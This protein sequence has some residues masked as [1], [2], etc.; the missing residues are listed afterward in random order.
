MLPNNELAK[1]AAAA[2]EWLAVCQA[3]IVMA[4]VPAMVAGS[5]AEERSR[6]ILPGLLATR[7]SGAAIIFDKLLAKM[8]QIGVFLA[9]GLP[10][11]C[12]L[13][14]FGGIDPRSIVYAYSGTIS[15][16]LFLAGLSLLVSVY[17]RGPR[18][19]IMIVYLIETFW[20]FGP[21]I[22]DVAM[23]MRMRAR[24]WV[25]PLATVNAWVLPITPLSL[26]TPGTLSGWNGRGPVAWLLETLRVIAPGS[27]TPGWTGPTALTVAWSRMILWQ[28]AVTS[29]FV[30]WA[31]W[32]IRPVARQLADAPRRRA[33]P[34]WLRGRS[35][36]RPRCGNDPML[37]KEC[38]SR[39]R[40]PAAFGLVFGILAFGL[41]TLF[42]HDRFLRLY[43]GALDELLAY[44]YAARPHR[45]EF[46]SRDGFLQ[47]LIVYS[48]LFYV[49][50]SLGVA[51]A[52]ATGVTLER[53]AGTWDGLLSTP[54]E[55]REIIRAK[56]LGAVIRQRTLLSLVLA[57]W[58]FGLALGALHPIG[59][60]LAIAGL[61]VFLCFASALGTL[62]SL[63]SKT[64]GRAVVR[65]LAVLLLLN[66]GT[67]V[68]ATTLMGSRDR[69]MFFGSTPMLLDALPI[70]NHF[71]QAI[72][73]RPD[74]A[75][76]YLGCL[77]ANVLAYAAL[78]WLLYRTAA[79]RFDL[80]A[81]R[82][83][84]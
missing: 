83:A 32:R 46:I 6:Q 1:F 71:M 50:T 11:A 30:L 70:S 40:I 39:D 8:L 59:L 67:V 49:A 81:G 18:A 24:L 75:A 51:V 77:S 53:E 76:L 65:T 13:G 63:R 61:A 28:L 54:L 78:A 37:W 31:S 48:V 52:A 27:L 73:N 19:A 4:I 2:F 22:V 57:P 62:F 16:A 10:I 55:P 74:K 60:L 58:L 5:V 64:S 42:T 41:W 21:W 34:T 20:L 45:G 36:A 84:M 66:L 43:R 68:V 17:A 80:V 47:A 33:G 72:V 25:G 26:V 79:R 3:L 14:L 56:V 7:L 23:T 15:T 38:T 9:V 82:A 35:R 44:G 29:V 12:L 69:A